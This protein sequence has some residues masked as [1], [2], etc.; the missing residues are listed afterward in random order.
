MA[1]NA[2]ISKSRSNTCRLHGISST[3]PYESAVWPWNSSGG[4]LDLVR[5]PSSVRLVVI[6]PKASVDIQLP[7]QAVDP[8][9]RLRR[10]QR[11]GDS[12]QFG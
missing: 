7:I 1:G 12:K 8:W 3:L 6:E 5:L 4:A 11:E 2:A 9:L 10:L